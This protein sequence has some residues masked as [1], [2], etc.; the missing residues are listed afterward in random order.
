M[1]ILA[2]QNPVFQKAMRIISNIANANPGSV[3]TTFNHNYITGQIV[4][5]NMAAG[6]GMDQLNQQQATITVTSDT[7]F[8]LD[9][10]T[11][12]FE[13]YTTPVTFP[14]NMQYSQVTPIGEINGILIAATQNVLPYAA[15]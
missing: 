4:R 14:K 8:D 13:P 6:Y 12:L 7:T 2:Q 3:T 15:T 10:D 11:T 9:I 5:I 1:A